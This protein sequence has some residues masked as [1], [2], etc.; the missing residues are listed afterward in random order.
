MSESTPAPLDDATEEQTPEDAASAYKARIRKS[1]ALLGQETD[2]PVIPTEEPP[3]LEAA[4]PGE[5]N[6]FQAEPGEDGDID[7]DVDMD[8]PVGWDIPSRPPPPGAW[9]VEKQKEEGASGLAGMPGDTYLMKKMS[10]EVRQMNLLYLVLLEKGV[11]TR[12][13]VEGSGAPSGDEEKG[14]G[15]EKRKPAPKRPKPSKASEED[16]EDDIVTVDDYDES[17]FRP[18]ITSEKDFSL[19]GL[20]K[21]IHRLK[22][23]REVLL[24]KGVVSQKELKKAEKARD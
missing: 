22:C 7:D 8:Q 23:L 18:I 5:K 1:G 11:V 15:P 14:K 13:E 21:D 20:V 19:S 9:V 10:E 24:K 3:P 17:Q 16:D 6:A 2:V 4:P 12:D